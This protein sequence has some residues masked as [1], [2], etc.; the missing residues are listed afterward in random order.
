MDRDLNTG[1][2]E[3]HDDVTRIMG[4]KRYEYVSNTQI[5]IQ[6]TRRGK[7]GVV[8]AGVIQSPRPRL[9]SPTILPRQKRVE[10]SERL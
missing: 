1:F 9:N 8:G 2:T 4:V 7:T 6:S 10:K 5:P 3:R